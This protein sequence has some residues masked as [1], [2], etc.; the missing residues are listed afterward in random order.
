MKYE[1]EFRAWMSNYISLFYVDVIT[2]SYTDHNDNLGN[3]C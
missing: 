1:H 3:I 2:Y